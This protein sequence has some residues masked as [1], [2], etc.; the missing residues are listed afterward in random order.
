MIIRTAII[1]SAT[2]KVVNI[3]E[4]DGVIPDAPDGQLWIA[5]DRAEIDDDWDGTAIVAQPRPDHPLADVKTVFIESLTVAC[6]AAITAGFVSAAIGTPTRY[7]SGR[8]DQSNIVNAA[9]HGGSIWCSSAGGDWSF[10]EHT[11]TQAIQV[12][13]DLW[14]HI[15]NQQTKYA[16]LIGK[17]NAITES[18][19]NAVDAVKKIVW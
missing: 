11:A 3:V 17:I 1:D 7:G 19:P 16:D 6:A 5:A 9:N 2:K 18:T 8:D 10:I 14:A 4:F 15:Q 12:R 13:A